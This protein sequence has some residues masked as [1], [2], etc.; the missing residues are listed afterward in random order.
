MCCYPNSGKSCKRTPQLCFHQYF[1][2]SL[3]YYTNIL[4]HTHTHTHII[5][6]LFNLHILR[7]LVPHMGLWKWL[8]M[9][10]PVSHTH[11]PIHTANWKRSFAD[12]WNAPTVCLSTCCLVDWGKANVAAHGCS[13]NCSLH[14]QNTGERARNEWMNEML[15]V[16][17]KILPSQPHHQSATSLMDCQ[18]KRKW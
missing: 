2:Q 7:R 13:L 14:N 11:T 16:H 4:M 5:V 10:T 12:C 3:S 6:S 15:T 8:Y 1:L 9:Q 17:T 18:K